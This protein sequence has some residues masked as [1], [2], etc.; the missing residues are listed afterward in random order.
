MTIDA[1]AN[2]NASA[3]DRTIPEHERPWDPLS[4]P[5][6]AE[7][8]RGTPF[9]W[10]IAGGH[11]IELAVGRPIR[12]HDGVD[13]LVLR[14]DLPAVR[15]HLAAWDCL[16]ADPPGSLR[17]WPVGEP[18]P[19]TAHD[20][21][22]REHATAPWRFQL[23]VDDTEGERWRSRRDHRVSLP[24]EHIGAVSAAGVPY[25]RPEV[26]LLA[27]AKGRRPRD[28]IDLAAALPVLTPPARAWLREA[29]RLT[30]G[31]DHPWLRRLSGPFG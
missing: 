1:N 20:I 29:I 11:A 10:W 14:D 26:Q 4:V 3:D 22:C 31:E 28:E 5:A 12:T 30:L 21:W 24:V 25:L 23:M 19:P 6:V 2:A 17:P 15:T 8:F 18:V 7:L 13:V 9:R 16:M 27:K